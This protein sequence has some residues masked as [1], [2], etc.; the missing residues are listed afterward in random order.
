MIKEKKM[1]L[2][3]QDAIACKGG[4]SA[5]VK[6]GKNKILE[7]EHHLKSLKEKL[8]TLE[9]MLPHSSNYQAH[10]SKTDDDQQ[11]TWYLSDN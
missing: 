5:R 8:N 2:R 11:G 6:R 7:M 10:E 9:T 3:K 1:K 4:S